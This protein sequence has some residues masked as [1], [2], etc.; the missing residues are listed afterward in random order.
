MIPYLLL[1]ILSIFMVLTHMRP[2]SML[3]VNNFS[4]SWLL[5]FVLLV[6]FIGFRYEVGADW[7]QYISLLESMRD[8]PFQAFL[9]ISDVGYG[10]LN[11]LGANIWGDIYLVNI[12]CALF[13]GWGLILFCRNQ[14]RPWLAL[15]VSIP[16]LVLVVAMGY[17]RQ[18]AAIG[19][20]MLAITGLQKEKISHYIFCV[21]LAA[22]F[23][24]SVIILLP[25]AI[26]ATSRYRLLTLFGVVIS[27]VILFVVLLL[28]QLDYVVLNYIEV[29]RESSGAIVRV[30]TNGIPAAL[31]LI[32]KERFG[33]N[34]ITR[35]FWVWMAWS[36]LLLIP[37]VLAFPSSTV[38]DRIAL[39][40][41]PIQMLVYSRLPDV[42]GKPGKKNP[43]WV[44][45]ISAYSAA[46]MLV[47]L[48]FGSFASYWLPYQFYPWEALWL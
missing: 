35:S 23:H 6:L 22:F 4:P 42:F 14:P 44:I 12:V 43:F 13:F 30:V 32:Y 21:M 45:L 37:L 15:L 2:Q 48:S 28:D 24:K 25:F 47:W 8:E 5:T 7:G 38:I 27:V 18:G 1:L 16:V 9:T 41:I 19:L 34:Q 29:E 20:A 11:W 46:I 33:I 26:F 17:T 40:W 39:Y 10:L 3:V 36:S 31:F